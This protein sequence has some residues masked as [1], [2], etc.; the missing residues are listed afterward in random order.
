MQ[1]FEIKA[2][3]FYGEVVINKGL[4]RNA[5]FGARAV[6]VY[7]GEWI[8]GQ[9][10]EGDRL[11]DDERDEIVKI[12]STIRRNTNEIP[13]FLVG[14]NIDRERYRAVS[15]EEGIET[16]KKNNFSFFSELSSKTG[17]NVDIT[18]EGIAEFLL[19]YYETKKLPPP[20]F[21]LKSSH[22]EV[23]D[24]KY[25]FDGTKIKVKFVAEINEYIDEL[26]KVYREWLFKS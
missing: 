5:G 13:I 6:P 8:I 1:S 25:D 7:V 21:K 19:D 12:L 18:F 10:M 23:F 16:A 20:V 4:M 15:R 17:Q 22:E 11:G 26:E 9:F 2:R 24:F 14:T 3:D